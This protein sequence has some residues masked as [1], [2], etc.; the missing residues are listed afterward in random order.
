MIRRLLQTILKKV[1]DGSKFKKGYIVL[2]CL[3]SDLLSADFHKQLN[4]KWF[5]SG[6]SFGSVH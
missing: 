4:T 3:G 2:R 1:L 5:T 6:G